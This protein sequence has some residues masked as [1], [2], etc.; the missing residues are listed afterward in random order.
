MRGEIESESQAPFGEPASSIEALSKAGDVVEEDN[1]T[2]RE[3][4]DG[5]S[6]RSPVISRTSASVWDVA[7]KQCHPMGAYHI[8][9]FLPNKSRGTYSPLVCHVSSEILLEGIS[10]SEKDPRGNGQAVPVAVNTEGDGHFIPSVV[11]KRKTV[12]ANIDGDLQATS[13]CCFT[14]T[15]LGAE[16]GSVLVT[17]MPSTND[18]D[19][20]GRE[21]SKLLCVGDTLMI[22]AGN[23]Y[24]IS[25][26]SKSRAA[27]LVKHCVFP[28]GSGAMT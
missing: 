14:Y 25:N 20:V 23:Q 21:T 9:E 1:V 16:D 26:T 24:R 2:M 19:T 11:V 5:E 6:A 17:V 8:W 12:P 4:G 15:L 27:V 28:V 3:T 7:R 10:L 22:P 13:S 18:N